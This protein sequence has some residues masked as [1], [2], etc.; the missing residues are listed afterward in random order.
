MQR[1]DLAINGGTVLLPGG[2]AR[3]NIGVRDER[4]VVLANEPLEADSVIDTTCKLLLPGAIDPHVHFRMLQRDTVTSDDY[5]SGYISAACGGV[6]TYIDF[7]VQ[8]V[9]GSALAARPC[10]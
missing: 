3:V 4:I 7:A 10:R 6:T 8:P 5:A 2:L 1:Y 9:G